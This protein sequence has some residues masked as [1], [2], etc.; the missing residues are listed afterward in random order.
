MNRIFYDDE[1]L[2]EYEQ[3]EQWDKCLEYLDQLMYSHPQDKSILY[4]FA[5]QSWYVLTFWDCNMPKCKLNRQEFELN[6]RIA[7]SL[8]KKR[9]WTDSDCLWLFGYFM[10]IN[11]MDFPYISSNIFEVERNGNRLINEAYNSNPKNPLAEIIFLA[12]SGNKSKYKAAKD[13]IFD[14]ISSYFP[15]GSAVGRYFIEIFTRDY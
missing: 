5:A 6:L 2:V 4:R 10:C 11:Q 9:W 14:H 13:K 8:A 7:Y 1:I 12:D 3:Q 15:S